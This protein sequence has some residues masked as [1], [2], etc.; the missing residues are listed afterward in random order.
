MI[1]TLSMMQVILRDA[2]F[3]TS[4]ATVEQVTGV[5]F[6]DDAVV[7]FGCVFN[8]CSALLNG[9]KGIET[10]F[11]TR[12]SQSLRRAGEKAWNVY[13]VLLSPQVVEST[14]ERQ[15]RWIEE[16]LDR[17][18]KITA[19]GVTTREDLV[20]ALLPLLPIQS[21][22]ALAT[23]NTA[24]RLKRRISFIAPRVSDL[25]LDDTVSP[26]ELVRLLG[27]PL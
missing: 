2:G 8:E 26:A 6:E 13:V 23:E 22:P 21:Q 25:A 14:V 5:C 19:C 9:W 3:V 11:L 16:D 10:S 15:I 20:T 1:D 12:H 27:E 24:E 17:T 7:G 4:A 18:R